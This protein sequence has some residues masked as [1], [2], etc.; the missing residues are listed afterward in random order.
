M[1]SYIVGQ[2]RNSDDVIAHYY[3]QDDRGNLT[4][5]CARGWN[6]DG[7]FGFSIFRGCTGNKGVCN[8][9]TRRVIQGLHGVKP[10]KRTTRWL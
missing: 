1:S 8:V 5:M 6:R 3:E 2:C 7:G 9:C 10:K 4:P